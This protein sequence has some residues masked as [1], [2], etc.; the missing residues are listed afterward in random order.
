[1]AEAAEALVI[2][3]PEVGERLEEVSPALTRAFAQAREAVLAGRPVVVVVE[4]RDLLGQGTVAAAALAT[5]LLGLARALALEGTRDGWRVSAVARGDAD[6]AALQRA[7][8]WAGAAP[9]SGQLLRAGSAHIGKVS[10]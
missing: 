5:G 9:L 2:S 1:M 7:I 4:D 8:D 10:P 6:E 3:Q